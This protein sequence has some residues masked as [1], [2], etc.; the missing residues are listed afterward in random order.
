MLSPLSP[1]ILMTERRLLVRPGNKSSG[2]EWSQF[3]L[4]GFNAAVSILRPRR[5]LGREPPLNE[6]G[7]VEWEAIDYCSALGSLATRPGRG[8]KPVS[9]DTITDVAATIVERNQTSTAGNSSSARQLNGVPD[10]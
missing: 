5:K 2:L 6:E 1:P 7:V 10:N 3:L 9:E 4:S 8:W